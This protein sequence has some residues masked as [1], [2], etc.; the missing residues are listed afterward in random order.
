MGTG[1]RG[2]ESDGARKNMKGPTH[3]RSGAIR[4]AA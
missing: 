2:K 3:E 4:H 1:A